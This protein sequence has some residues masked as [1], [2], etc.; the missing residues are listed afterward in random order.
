MK[1]R[2]T[3]AKST[4]RTVV[5]RRDGKLFTFREQSGLVELPNGERRVIAL[6][7]EEGQGPYPV[8]EYTVLDSSMFVDRN[9]K[10]A[11]GRLHLAPV[12]ATVVENRQKAG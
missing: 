12:V 11:L 5:R 9:N 2:V 6:G 10:L 3:E 4:E 8:G 1:I 7:L